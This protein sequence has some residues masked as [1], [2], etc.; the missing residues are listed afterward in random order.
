MDAAV[1]VQRLM[2]EFKDIEL[3]M[4]YGRDFAQMMRDLNE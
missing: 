1:Y 2:E 3:T 4:K